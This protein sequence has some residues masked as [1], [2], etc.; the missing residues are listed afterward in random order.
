[1]CTLEYQSDAQKKKPAVVSNSHTY[2]IPTVLFY[3][4]P[5]AVVTWY[6]ASVGCATTNYLDVIFSLLN[7]KPVFGVFGNK[8][9]TTGYYTY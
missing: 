8:F 6:D 4:A 2:K 5:W 1:M 7:E 3:G 9:V